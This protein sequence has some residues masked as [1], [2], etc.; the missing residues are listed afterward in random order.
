MKELFFGDLIIVGLLVLGF[1]LT[2]ADLASYQ[3]WGP[4]YEAAHRKV[5][6]ET[7]S[8]Q[9]GSRKDFENLFVS[10]QTASDPVSKQAILSVLK[11][12]VDL[13]SPERKAEIVPAEVQQLINAKQ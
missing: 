9:D 13:L 6:E 5:Y 4:K 7:K 2:G 8:Y 11:D 3:F 10:Y 1:V 12:R